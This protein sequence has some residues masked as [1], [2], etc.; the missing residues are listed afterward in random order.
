MENL[1]RR[2]LGV[3]KNKLLRYKA[4][5]ELYQEKF[6]QFTHTPL[7]QILKNYIY[8]FYPIYVMS[9]NDF[10]SSKIKSSKWRGSKTK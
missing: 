6:K 3:K 2:Q 8:P 1:D 9:L 7:T 10:K 4:I 5:K